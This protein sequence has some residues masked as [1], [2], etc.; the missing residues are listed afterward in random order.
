VPSFSHLGPLTQRFPKSQLVHYYLGLLLAWTA[1][2]QEAV[3]QFKQ[4]QSLGPNT[5][6]GKQAAQFLAGIGGSASAK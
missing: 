3:K 4:T 5:T 6:L 1:Q 2:G